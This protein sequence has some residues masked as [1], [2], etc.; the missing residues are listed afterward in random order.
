MKNQGFEQ[1]WSIW[2]KNTTG[3][4]QRKGGK[5]ICLKRWEKGLYWTQADTIIKHTEWMK[6]TADWMK[7]RGAFIPMP[8]TYLNQQRWD[9]ADIE[10]V[11][12]K[13]KAYI[14]PA[15][16]AVIEQSAKAVKPSD[17]IRQRL[18]AIRNRV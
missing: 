14:D 11:I 13:P 18:A 16:M 2:P 7:D 4:Y 12:E 17:E 8:I 5:S 6:T 9:G 1:W 3:G 10:V 15:V